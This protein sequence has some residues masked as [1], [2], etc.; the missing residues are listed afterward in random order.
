MTDEAEVTSIIDAAAPGM[1]LAN[2][3]V[4]FGNSL[5]EPAR[6]AAKLYMQGFTQLI[7]VTGGPRRNDPSFV[8]AERH[9]EVLMACGVPRD[10]ILIEPR[11]RNTIENAE[12]SAQLL[13]G[14]ISDP[15]SII[16]ILLWW[17]R[18]ALYA[19]SGAFPA[20]ERIYTADYEPVI[21]GELVSRA[22][23]HETACA[24]KLRGEAARL[25]AWSPGALAELK[26]TNAGW[27]VR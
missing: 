17:H 8:E 9:M 14:V 25:Q 11:S 22:S 7:V 24:A 5:P 10:H 19:L 3:A 21:R 13:R 23:W 4:I 2:C 18:R 16:A 20:L 1:A 12:F 27:A 15:K 6:I 26:R